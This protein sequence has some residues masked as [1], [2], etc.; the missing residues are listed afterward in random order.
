MALR[1]CGRLVCLLLVLAATGLGWDLLQIVAW[2]GMFA[3]NLRER[4][5]S[6]AWTRTFSDEGRCS[7][8]HALERVRQDEEESQAPL[9]LGLRGWILP[10]VVGT[11]LFFPPPVRPVPLMTEAM[12]EEKR[13]HAPALPPPR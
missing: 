5:V 10:L 13:A 6:A 3:D 11:V 9:A 7:L 2:G 1:K 12:K 4:D 8:C